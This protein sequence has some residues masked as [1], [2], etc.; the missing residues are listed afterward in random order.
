MSSQPDSNSVH[1]LVRDRYGRIA[2][3]RRAEPSCCPTTA[4][5][6]TR[7]G[8]SAEELATLP[9]GA[10]L[11][12]GSGNPVAEGAIQPGEVVLDLG[13]GGG[14]DCI[15]AARQVGPGGRVIG[16]DM[17]EAMLETAR[18]AAREAGLNNVEFRQGQIEA[19][20]LDD[21]SVDVVISNCVVNLSPDKAAVWN[22]VAR[23]LK[24]GGRV[25]ISD[26]VASAPLPAALREKPELL[27]GC[28]SGAAAME[29]VRQQVAGAGLRDVRIEPREDS[30]RSIRQW[31]PE[32]AEDVHVIS[33]MI[34]ARK[35]A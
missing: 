34:H 26:I 8:Y 28:I 25:A 3:E 31:V 23:V 20:P 17:T 29:E 24:P 33:A 16:V 27:C 15:L 4:S 22:E 14:I 7:L 35:P 18:G 10:D 19:L 32:A 13:S 6:S 30:Y 12:L 2:N 5:G 21:A 1:K 11:G 9:A